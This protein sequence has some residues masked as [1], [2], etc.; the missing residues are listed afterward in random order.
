MSFT[1]YSKLEKLLHKSNE[2]VVQSETTGVDIMDKI[3]QVESSNRHFDS[4]GKLIQSVAGALGKYQ[5]KPSTAKN[6]GFGVEPIPDLRKASEEEHRRLASDY[7]KAMLN[8]FNGD[9][10]KALA[11]YNAGHQTVKKAIEKYG[12]EWKKHIPEETKNYINKIAS[13]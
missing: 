9:E 5:I 11:A 2:P 10:E 6:P 1:P 8:E 13:L 12:V 7:Y 4:A 3:A